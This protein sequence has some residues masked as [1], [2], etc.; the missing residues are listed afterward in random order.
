MRLNWR[1]DFVLL[2][3]TYDC[4]IYLVR[5]GLTS[6][7]DY[8][9]ST[10]QGQLNA[11]QKQRDTV[12]NRLK[13]ATKYNTTQQL[14]EK[15]G[16]TPS[17]TKSAGT[18]TSK[19]T[20]SQGT[21]TSKERRGDFIPP[22]TA[23]IPR[24]SVGTSLPNT[25]LRSTSS[26]THQSHTPPF[27][28]AAATA[29]WQSPSSPA[30]TTAEFAPNAFSSVPQY[31]QI[32]DGSRWYDRLMDVL[33][34]EDET[35]PKNRLTLICK[36]CRLVN[37]QAPPGAKSLQ[38]VGTWRCSGCGRMNGEENETK[39]I[40]AEAQGRVAPKSSPAS[41]R[42]KTFPTREV[43]GPDDEVV[44]VTNSDGHESGSTQYSEDELS[45]SDM[46]ENQ[47]E[48]TPDPDPPARKRGRPKGGVKNKY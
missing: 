2:D 30:E 23:N 9:T 32:T 33:L 41:A 12:I 26:S 29:P 1:G 24:G 22:P 31:A 4:S 47:R 3:L 11:L 17:K 18:F 37:G 19:P 48:P 13:A 25:P 35:L 42:S 14:L 38:D 6:Y 40:V 45:A 46:K 20:P 27:S 34:G 5:L 10:L 43:D 8:R 36:Q 15:Y 44:L 21:D 39:K 16:G 28:A 7:Y